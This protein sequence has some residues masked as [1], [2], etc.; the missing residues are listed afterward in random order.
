MD[1]SAAFNT[2]D[3]E[4]LLNILKTKFGVED[5]ALRRFDSYLHPIS[6]KVIIDGKY[7]REVDLDVSMP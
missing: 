2:V 1:L 6:Y 4:I 5:K 7:S 3:H